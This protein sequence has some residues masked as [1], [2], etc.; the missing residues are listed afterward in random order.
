[1]INLS[2]FRPIIPTMQ[3]HLA[4]FLTAAFT[5]LILSASPLPAS[6][7]E[8]INLP[9]I[10]ES[11]G[12]LLTPE[13]EQLMGKEFMRSVRASLTLLDDPLI[14]DYLQ[15]LGE[16][17]VSQVDD[18]D[19][20]ISLFLINDP[21][22]NAFAGPGGYIGVHTGLIL[23]A[24]T[25]DEL[26]SVLAHE[27]AHVVQRHI[28]RSIE[29]SQHLELST[30][31]TMIAAIILGSKSPAATEAIL[32][33][34]M[35]GAAQQQLTF[36]RQ[37]E[38]EADRVG[39]D[40]MSR[41]GFNPRQMVAF[42]EILQ[43]SGRYADLQAMEFLQTHPLTL[44]RIA[45]TRN[46]AEQYPTSPVNDSLVFDLIRARTAFLTKT[47]VKRPDSSNIPLAA[48]RYYELL[49][50][51]RQGKTSAAL[52]I[53]TDLQKTDRP[54]VIYY[55]TQAELERATDHPDRAETAL[56]QGLRLF[57]NNY[58]L[59]YLLAEILLDNGKATEAKELLQEQLRLQP[60]RSLYALHSRAAKA[61]GHDA[62]AY[63]S[64]ADLYYYDGNTLQAIDYLSKAVEL[65]KLSK[66]DQLASKAQLEQ[67]K[68][69]QQAQAKQV[70]TEK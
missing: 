20:K 51:H 41:A 23:A 27:L 17:L 11:A 34:G 50:L 63:V 66:H 10:G 45:D 38:Q 58:P 70:K 55:L 12:T 47:T 8:Q 4:L 15:S 32:S 56:R 40:M 68:S 59:S 13:Q 18:F 64:L 39:L 52:E 16:R 35:A 24:E 2:A 7:A 1:M 5:T 6:G 25:E 44:S 48:Q 65:Q 19:G 30:M 67:W 62:E 43:K 14:E 69:E 26:A 37:H 3:S 33:S 42:F 21:S 54:R 61:D 53:L 57:P 46:R 28:F 29:A 22:I 36:S 49:D 9:D 31:A 60:R